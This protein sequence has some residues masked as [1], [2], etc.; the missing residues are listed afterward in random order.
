MRTR[1]GSVEGRNSLRRKETGKNCDDCGFEEMMMMM[2][3]NITERT[4]PLNIVLC[5]LF[6]LLQGFLF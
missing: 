2:T 1:I 5:F 4:N 6:M 3:S